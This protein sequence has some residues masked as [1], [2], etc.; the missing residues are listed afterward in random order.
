M[1]FSREM[2][3]EIGSGKLLNVVILSSLT[4][5]LNRC[6]MKTNKM[7]RRL[8]CSN[9][10]CTANQR[11]W[12]RHMDSTISHLLELFALFCECTNRPFCVGSGQNPKFL[13]FSCSGLF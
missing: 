12:F 1:D 13:I 4:N 3:I 10:Y 5:D 8:L 11:H 7:R 9:F 6:R 2:K